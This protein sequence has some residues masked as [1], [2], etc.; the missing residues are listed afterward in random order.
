MSWILK[1]EV[2]LITPEC[3]AFIR[4]VI[5]NVCSQ[6]ISL[7]QCKTSLTPFLTTSGPLDRFFAILSCPPN[8]FPFFADRSFRGNRVKKR[9]IPWIEAEDNRLLAAI[10]RFGTQA[11]PAVAA[12]VGNRRTRAQCAQ[13]WFRG[14]DPR[15]SKEGWSPDDDAKLL[16]LV[17]ARCDEGWTWISKQM[18]NRSD[19][20]CRYRYVQLRRDGGELPTKV[21]SNPLQHELAK[22]LPKKKGR[23]MK[24]ELGR[25][26]NAGSGRVEGEGM[27][28]KENGVEEK[29]KELIER[30]LDWDEEKADEAEEMMDW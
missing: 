30:I 9:A 20:Q 11:W 8:P 22:L 24:I 18:G 17:A 6:T 3:E 26:G 2:N 7:N 14:L 16:S 10:H 13:R 23:P 21:E 1:H 19:V 25:S 5:N 28:E 15:I 29:E 12:F 27:R 4:S